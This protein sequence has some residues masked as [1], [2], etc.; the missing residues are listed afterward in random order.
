MN[1]HTFEHHVGLLIFPQGIWAEKDKERIINSIE[2][3]KKSKTYSE[4]WFYHGFILS[5]FQWKPNPKGCAVCFAVMDH[6]KQ[7]PGNHDNIFYI[8][9]P[10]LEDP[11]EE[12]SK[13]LKEIATSNY[14][15]L[16]EMIT[17]LVHDVKIKKVYF[18]YV[19][20]IKDLG[21]EDKKV[22]NK[23]FSN[24]NFSKVLVNERIILKDFL[25]LCKNFKVSSGT[26][27]EIMRDYSH[28]Y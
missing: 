11:K 7:L 23:S 21:F 13:Y 19:N 16:R 17:S 4:W 8:N 26:V 28:N 2:V 27:Y 1:Q 25:N 18:L 12:N 24:D 6:F 14:N 22:Y 3:K 15:Y 9:G 10:Y 20:S 5:S